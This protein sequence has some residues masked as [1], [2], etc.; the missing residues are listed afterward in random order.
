M[1]RRRRCRRDRAD[2]DRCQ[3]SGRLTAGPRAASL[4]LGQVSIELP[5]TDDVDA[6]VSRLRTA[7]VAAR[8]DGETLRFDDPWKTLI[9]VHASA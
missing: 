1:S 9:E 6:L 4:G 8:H 2:A 3:A 5:T 7:G